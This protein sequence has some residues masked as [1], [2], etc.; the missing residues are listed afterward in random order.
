MDKV[1]EEY[2]IYSCNECNSTAPCIIMRS[3][4]QPS[5]EGCVV[6]PPNDTTQGWTEPI[7]REH[8]KVG[9]DLDA[10]LV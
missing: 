10:C 4:D 8:R 2:I 7:W 3:K 5:P 9:L 6:V 1:R